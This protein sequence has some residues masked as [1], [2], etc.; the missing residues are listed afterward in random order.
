MILILGFIRIKIANHPFIVL[1]VFEPFIRGGEFS[2][3]R[4]LQVYFGNKVR[5]ERVSIIRQTQSEGDVLL[6][7]LAY[8]DDGI[9]WVPG[10]KVRDSI[11]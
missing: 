2:S 7:N 9:S 4:Y 5:V 10:D 1:L 6:F 11:F 8:S 3:K